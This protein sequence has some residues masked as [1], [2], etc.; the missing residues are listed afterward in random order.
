MA[1]RSRDIG[2]QYP[3][4]SD[5]TTP[6]DPTDDFSE[7]DY[8]ILTPDRLGSGFISNPLEGSYA[9]NRTSSTTETTDTDVEIDIETTPIRDSLTNLESTFSG[10]LR[11]V[12]HI[13]P[14]FV[15]SETRLVLDL[16]TAYAVY[17]DD[18]SDNIVPLMDLFPVIAT[19][20]TEIGLGEYTWT[21]TGGFGPSS[22]NA[23]ELNSS[24]GILPGTV[25]V[26]HKVD[27]YWWFF[28]PVESCT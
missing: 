20:T 26:L 16:D 1:T 15:T 24:T 18:G 5:D 17:I 27:E 22:G 10:V 12:D 8:D 14:E 6:D 11:L 7:I 21:K 19:I 4:D 28:Y 9:Y 13:D 25:V 3:S 2:S 23:A